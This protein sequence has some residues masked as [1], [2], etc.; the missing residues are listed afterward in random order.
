MTVGRSRVL[1]VD[2]D[3]DLRHLIRTVLERAG[4]AVSCAESG[5]A[6]MRALFDD[7][8]DLVVVDLGLPDLE[9]V[10]LIGRIRD[11]SDVGILVLTARF[12]EQEKVRCF[13]A[14][15]DDYV[16]KPFGNA[17]LVARVQALLRRAQP[18]AQS[19]T[20]D[21]GPLHI[22]LDGHRV[23]LDGVE[24]PLTPTDWSLLVALVRHQGRILSP[25]Q[26]LELAWKDPAGIGPDRVKFAV[27]RLR[28]RF[29]WENPSTS[30][31][32]SVRGFGYRYRGVASLDTDA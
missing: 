24:V 4:L 10:E 2:D 31:I 29:G 3:G 16:T 12:Q 18:R 20:F 28:R 17:E 5:R 19:S 21:D 11:A 13:A 23:T 6:G 32:E 8:P 22:D 26:L 1:V 27:L 9:G 7:R 14:G 30:P 25:G 15:A